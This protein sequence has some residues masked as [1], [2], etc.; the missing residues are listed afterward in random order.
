MVAGVAALLV[1]SIRAIMGQF[2]EENHGFLE[3]VSVYWHFVH[4]VWLFLFALLWQ[5][6]LVFN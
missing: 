6:A 5:G 3:A 2:S 1:V 4:I